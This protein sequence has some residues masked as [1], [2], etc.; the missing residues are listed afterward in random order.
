MVCL[1]VLPTEQVSHFYASN[2]FFSFSLLIK[3]VVYRAS[4][5]CP[6]QNCIAAKGG[7]FCSRRLQ[8]SIQTLW[9]GH[10]IR[11][12]KTISRMG[13]RI[14]LFTSSIGKAGC[15]AATEKDYIRVLITS[16]LI[17]PSCWRASN[18]PRGGGFN[19]IHYILQ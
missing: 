17:F 4:S 3:S 8:P 10:R 12:I 7:L 13:G 11:F 14:P 15:R 19:S 5:D 6:C 2:P 1:P 9:A 18:R 16:W